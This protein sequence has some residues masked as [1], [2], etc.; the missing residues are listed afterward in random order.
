M[1]LRNWLILAASGAVLAACGPSKEQ[2]REDKPPV[3]TAEPEKKPEPL[4]ELVVREVVVAEEPE[5]V[6]G[7]S[8]ESQ[9]AFREG[10]IAVYSSPPAYEEAAAQ[11]REAIRLEPK[12]PEAYFNLG[13]VLQRQ[14]KAAEAF[15]VYQDALAAMPDNTDVKAYIGRVHL[16]NAKVAASEGNLPERDRLLQLARSQFELVTAG[17]KDNVEANN[18]MALYWLMRGDLDKAEE[19]VKKVLEVDPIDMVALNTRGLI[20]YEKGN[21]LIAKWIYEQK[22]LRIDDRSD[23]ADQLRAA[24]AASEA[25]NNLGLTYIKLDMMPEA[26]RSLQFAVEAKP[27][28]VEAR[29]NLAAIYLSFLDYERA[30]EQYDAVLQM[31]PHNI[32]AVTGHGS[33]LYGLG[34]YEDAIAHYRK[35][36]ETEPARMDLILRIALIYETRVADLSRAIPVYEEYIAKKALPPD[37]ELVGKVKVLKMMEKGEPMQPLGDDDEMI[38][39]EGD[40]GMEPGDDSPPAE[41][42]PAT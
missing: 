16:G 29:L 20:N 34:Q 35:V 25:W 5:F 6:P 2:V 15:K 22:V 7:L 27:D 3:A 9:R 40:E 38:P 41:G 26:V 12:F 8:E 13:M 17:E 31:Q 24:E 21:F 42:V 18:G 11:F 10:V 37:H 30:R 1:K 19:F 33:A 14:G 23:E 36:L 39:L 32:E 28:N 4:E